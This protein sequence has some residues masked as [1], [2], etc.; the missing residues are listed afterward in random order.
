[1]TERVRI[2]VREVLA[3]LH[4]EEAGI[5]EALRAEGLFLED[6]LAPDVAE[7][8]RVAACLMREL[9]VNPAG[10]D[11]ALHLRR[12]LAFLEERMRDLLERLDGDPER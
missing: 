7:E 10:V 5:L 6:E 8:L 3:F 4:A 12:R 2:R 1:M 11:V 9:G